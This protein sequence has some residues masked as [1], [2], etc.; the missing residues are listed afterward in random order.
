MRQHAGILCSA[1]LLGVI[2]VGSTGCVGLA[3]GTLPPKLSA[4]EKARLKDAHL[5]LTVGVESQDNTAVSRLVI[6]Q[7]RA[8]KLFDVVDYVDRLP[9]PPNVLARFE[10]TPYG[11]ATVPCLTLVTFGLIPTIVPEPLSFGC[12]FYSPADPE[13]K[14][15]VEY[16][17]ESQT[18][19]GWISPLLAVAPG[20]V[21]L[22]TADSHRRFY[23]R[24]SLAIL[25]RSAELR[26][27]TE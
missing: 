15:S 2:S 21:I 11:T 27:L 20:V 12:S 7:L 9:G 17:Y 1:L 16:C 26:E 10:H 4:T 23:D 18:I 14:V 13:R 25:D 24:L 6:S 22:T 5:H 19:L 8:T 3:S